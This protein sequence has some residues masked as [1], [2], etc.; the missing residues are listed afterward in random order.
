MLNQISPAKTLTPKT[1]DAVD[2][3]VAC[4]RR[5][6]H[7]TETS[8]R[9]A[10]AQSEAL[11]EIRSASAGVYRYFSVSLPLH[12]ADEEETL[13]PRLYSTGDERIRRALL[14]MHDQ[15]MAID[16]LIERLLPLLLLLERNPAALGEVGGE[17]C[18][19]T[20]ALR[21]VFD[22]HLKLEEEVLF[23][24]IRELLPENERAAMLSE[25]R[26]RRQQG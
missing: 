18:S 2:L 12:E 19:I 17:M 1:E 8:A 5:I 11:D 23:P 14:A 25:M 22:A 3:L 20:Q 9:L 26:S 16:E 15:H 4:H 10:H 7:F 6:R 21:D 13:R 24:A